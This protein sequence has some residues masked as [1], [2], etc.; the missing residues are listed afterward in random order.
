MA[1][2]EDKVGLASNIMNK[3]IKWQNKVLEMSSNCWDKK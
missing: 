2:I 1:H 3:S